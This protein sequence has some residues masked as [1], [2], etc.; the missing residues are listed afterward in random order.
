MPHPDDASSLILVGSSVDHKDLAVAPSVF[1]I[2][3][4]KIEGRFTGTG[5]LFA[6]VFLARL[7]QH[8]SDVA[9][10]AEQVRQSP[11]ATR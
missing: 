7:A 8:P 6:A 9:K 10:A 5:D 3:L 1:T 4:P 11:D 2:T